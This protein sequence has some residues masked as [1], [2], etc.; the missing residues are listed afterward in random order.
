MIGTVSE[1]AEAEQ[2]AIGATSVRGRHLPALDG[3][4]ALAVLLVMAYHLGFA[5]ANGGF[6]GV[7][8]FFVLSGFLITSLLVEERFVDGSI[9]LAAFWGRRA[10]RLLPATLCLIVVIAVALMFI[11]RYWTGPND[12]AFD[13]IGFKGDAYATL[14]YVANWHAI[15][16]HQNYFAAFLAPSPLKHTWSLSIEEQFYLVWPL[17][18]VAMVRKSPAW[19]RVGIVVSITM[20]VLST[21]LMAVLV[22]GGSSLSNV[23]FNTFARLFDLGAG[24]ALAF[25]VALRPSPSSKATTTLNVLGPVAFV[26]LAFFWSTAGGPDGFPARGMFFGGFALC[27]VLATIVVASVRLPKPTIFGRALGIRPLAWVGLI[28]YGLYLWHWPLFQIMTPSRIHLF[29]WKLAVA[30]IVATFVFATLSFYLLERPIRRRT[31]R[32]GVLPVLV[33]A[34]MVGTAAVV[35]MVNP[36]TVPKLAPTPPTSPVLPTAQGTIPGAGGII[37][38]PVHFRHAIDPEH[39]LNVLIVGDSVMYS[40]ELPVNRGLRSTM[41]AKAQM[42]AFPGWGLTTKKIWRQELAANLAKFPID[43]V[44]GTWGWDNKV[45]HDHPERYRA[46]LQEFVDRATKGPNAAAAVGFVEYPK[47]GDLAWLGNSGAAEVLGL[48]GGEAAFAQVAKQVVAASPGRALYLPTAPSILY[49]G[50]FAS[51]LPPS[52]HRAAPPSAWVRVR[53]VD[54]I[55]ACQPGAVNEAAAIIADLDQL[56]G[57]GAPRGNWYEGRWVHDPRYHGGLIDCPNDHPPKGFR[58]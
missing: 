32:K 17:A 57:I 16:A 48:T 37:G 41:N 44:I 53:S 12:V 7:D 40:I 19:R 31:F 46:L 36:Y 2:A 25:M 42:K 35:T 27:A 6:L 20:A 38:A 50:N 33:V 11:R 22:A 54:S 28:S 26:V 51:W 10:K 8:L 56:A 13:R 34:G 45:A 18:V 43:L 49:K 52:N 4:R 1:H 14:L 29:G 21:V 30:K 58:P 15:F 47:T 39:P 9:R 3:L 55:H 23:Y 24:A 5:W